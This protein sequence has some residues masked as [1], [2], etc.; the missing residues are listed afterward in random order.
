MEGLTKLVFLIL[1]PGRRGGR[2]LRLAGGFV[3]RNVYQS[4][5]QQ[6]S[7]WVVELQSSCYH[8][9]TSFPAL[10]IMSCNDTFYDW[11]EGTQD[12]ILQTLGHCFRRKVK[13]TGRHKYKSRIHLPARP[14]LEVVDGVI[15]PFWPGWSQ[16]T[17]WM[18]RTEFKT[19]LIVYQ[20][21]DADHI[22]LSL[23]F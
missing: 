4:K 10:L 23:Y 5:T 11:L 1:S 14:R 16:E 3:R 12:V 18:A 13:P 19:G 8:V 6:S 15:L 7:D 17:R 20:I 9:P 2:T 22:F 21:L